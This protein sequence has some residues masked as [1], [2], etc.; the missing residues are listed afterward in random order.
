MVVMK[1]STM[2]AHT[3]L[4]LNTS[5]L[6][7]EYYINEGIEEREEEVRGQKRIKKQFFRHTRD[8]TQ[9]STSHTKA[10]PQVTCDS[11]TTSVRERKRETRA[12]GRAIGVL[13]ECAK[14]TSK[15]LVLAESEETQI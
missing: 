14:L 6:I 5:S 15:K 13:G 11:S 12:S 8:D 9:I 3:R 2:K 10:L 1:M 4:D 7:C